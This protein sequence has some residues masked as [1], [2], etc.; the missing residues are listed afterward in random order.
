MKMKALAESVDR[1]VPFVMNIQ[2]QFGLRTLLNYPD[3]YV[4]LLKKLVWLSLSPVPQKDIEL[5]LNRERKL[6]EVLKVDSVSHDTD[7]FESMCVMKSGP[8]R[9]LLSG[10]DLKCRIDGGAVQQ[11][12]DFAERARELFEDREMGSDALAALK[13]YAAICQKIRLQLAQDIPAMAAA[14]RWA[15]KVSAS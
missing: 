12:L 10:Y 13:N 7:W 3:G 1:S 5:L 4:A 2:R 15:R 8:T 14:L 11:G 9:L 6:L